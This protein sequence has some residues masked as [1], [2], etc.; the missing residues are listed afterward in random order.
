MAIIQYQYNE[1]SMYF[2]LAANEKDLSQGD[3]KDR[4]KFKV[5]TL[6]DVIEC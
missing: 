1:H 4:E 5:E 6:D 2:H 3:W